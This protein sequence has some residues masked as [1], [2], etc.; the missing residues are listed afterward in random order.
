[1]SFG[2]NNYRFPMA[3]AGSTT[4]TPYATV[5][6]R[7]DCSFNDAVIVERPR[8]PVVT[9]SRDASLGIA[10]CSIDI[11]KKEARA[12]D[13]EIE[14]LKAVIRKQSEELERCR[15]KEENVGEI[16]KDGAENCK[17]TPHEKTARLTPFKEYLAEA[18]RDCSSRGVERCKELDGV[19]SFVLSRKEADDLVNLIVDLGAFI[20]SV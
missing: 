3:K 4:S 18:L 1:M 10:L 17:T 14:E 8:E 20:S 16:D 13:N 15:A 2:N 11:L 7:G 6:T 19:Q 9:K 12:K 5:I